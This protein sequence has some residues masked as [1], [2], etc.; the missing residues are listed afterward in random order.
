MDIPTINA[1]KPIDALP[2][3]REALTTISRFDEHHL[4]S[5]HHVGR[6]LQTLKAG[7]KKSSD[8]NRHLTNMH[9]HV[10]HEMCLPL[11]GHAAMETVDGVYAFESPMVAV[12]EPGMVHCE[13][14]ASKDSSHA[15][16]W[17]SFG[18]AYVL[19]MLSIYRPQEQWHTPLR[20]Q[21]TGRLA[22]QLF[23]TLPVFGA[24]GSDHASPLRFEPFRLALLA[25]TA[26]VYR[27]AMLP[28]R[29]SAMDHELG[30]HHVTL[31]K[32][33]A[34]FIEQHLDQPIRLEQ[35]AS[36]AHLSPNHLNMLFRR[37]TGQPM[38]AWI[39][40]KRMEKA[41]ALLQQPG[42]LAKQVAI[43]T[44]YDDPLYFSR[45]FHKH[46]GFWPTQAKEQTPNPPSA[47]HANHQSD[48]VK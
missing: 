27:Q 35:L 6:R 41:M 47:S 30:H 21:V 42:S 15:V 7:R 43:E 25:L 37:W 28:V 18:K 39:V 36:L 22:S 11:A 1:D 23:V 19:S 12:F 48:R 29:K 38:H 40:T 14:K 10:W 26:E 33:L 8:S 2:L 9:A 32:Q 5:A 20:W 16:L 45:A 4:L 34:I 17:F 24:G 3:L 44:G 31:L 13:R 46:F